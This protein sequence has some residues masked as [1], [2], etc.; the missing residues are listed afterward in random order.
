M[1]KY[2][3]NF[4]MNPVSCNWL[5]YIWIIQI[6]KLF[7][8]NMELPITQKELYSQLQN[9]CS[10]TTGILYEINDELMTGSYR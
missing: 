2:S 7:V 8:I 1:I 10:N 6:Y 3:S 9:M 4:T 5:T